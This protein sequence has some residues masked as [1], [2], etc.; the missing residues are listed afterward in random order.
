M[1][2]AKSVPAYIA[3]YPKDVQARLKSLRAAVRKAAPGAEEKIAYGM[4]GYKLF[5]RP[6]VYIGGFQK[7]VGFFAMPSARVKFKKELAKYEGGKSAIQFPHDEPV[8]YG[9][10]AKLVKFRSKEN[11]K[12]A[13]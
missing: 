10:V 3:S 2:A 4:I 13:K 12:K 8:P 6:L 7:H 5:G 9:L 1:K 11:A